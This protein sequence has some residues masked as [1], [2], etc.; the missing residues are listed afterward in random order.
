MIYMSKPTIGW[1]VDPT[2]PNVLRFWDGANWSSNSRPNRNG[3]FARAKQARVLASGSLIAFTLS[4]LY[5]LVLTFISLNGTENSYWIQFL[6]LYQQFTLLSYGTIFLIPVLAFLALR[7]N[8][9]KTIP[10]P[11]EAGANIVVIS[12]LF[13]LLNLGDWGVYIRFIFSLIPA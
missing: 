10:G 8:R 3:P 13:T 12:S 7:F 11:V 9:L 1:R 4:F 2:N 5:I 6:H